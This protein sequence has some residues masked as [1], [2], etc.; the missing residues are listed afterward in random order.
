MTTAE[1]AKMIDT[2]LKA[3]CKANGG[4]SFIA[5]DPLDCLDRLRAKP[6]TPTAAV[7][8]DSRKPAGEFPELARRVNHFK[9][10]VSRGRGLKLISGESLTEGAAGGRPMFDLVEEAEAVVLALRV[11]EVGE[12]SEFTVPEWD[13]T[14]P[15]E[16]NGVLLDASEIRFGLYAQAEVQVPDLVEEEE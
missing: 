5:S 1:Q 10:V 6:G 2:A 16:V 11:E 3:W 13:G 7:L 14:G 9:V 15:W 8:W 4:R 12:G